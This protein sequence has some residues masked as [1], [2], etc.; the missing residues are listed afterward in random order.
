MLLLVAPLVFTSSMSQTLLSQMGI[1]IIVCLC[2]NMLL[3]QGGML[4]FGHSHS[5]PGYRGLAAAGQSDSAAGRCWQSG[6]GAAA[7]LGHHPKSR[8]PVCHDLL[9]H[10]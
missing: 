2:Y 7:G 10:G 3:G 9:W 8:H 4:S 6:I 5:E 1:A